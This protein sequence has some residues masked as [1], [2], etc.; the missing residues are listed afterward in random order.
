MHHQSADGILSTDDK[1]KRREAH[2]AAY[3]L[4]GSSVEL[5]S[6]PAQGMPPGDCFSV[7]PPRRLQ[8][9]SRSVLG[10]RNLVAA[11]E[12]EIAFVMGTKGN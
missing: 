12:E 4:R 7:G 5:F 10:V 3:I 9:R 8:Q 1:T 6:S 11:Q 2:S